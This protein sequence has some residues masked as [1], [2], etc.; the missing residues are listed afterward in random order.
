MSDDARQGYSSALA[1]DG[2]RD[3]WHLRWSVVAVSD[4]RIQDKNRVVALD[5]SGEVVAHAWRATEE[6]PWLLYR[7]KLFVGHIEPT[8]PEVMQRKLVLACLATLS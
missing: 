5:N 6:L 7:G 8:I 4:V 2:V 1:L 3:H